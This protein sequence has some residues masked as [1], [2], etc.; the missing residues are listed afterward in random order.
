M[1]FLQNIYTVI[2]GM[3]AL[4]VSIFTIYK[5]WFKKWYEKY[6]A[7]KKAEEE[8]KWLKLHESIKEIRDQVL[9]NGGSS[10]NDIQKEMRETLDV[11]VLAVNSLSVGQRNFCDILDIASWESDAEGRVTYAS[12]GLCEL[13]NAHPEEIKGNSWVGLIADFD[14]DRIVKGWREAVANAS[15]FRMEHSIEIDEGVYQ[16][17]K[18]I[19]IHNKDKT[20]RVLNSMGRLTKDGE[21][22]KLKN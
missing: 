18:P 2:I 7:K 12:M 16:R 5:L 6:R 21:P 8:A 14:R 15:D 9:P 13:M 17:V 3:G 10:M 20:G 1:T 19:V 11:V 4:S 22:Y